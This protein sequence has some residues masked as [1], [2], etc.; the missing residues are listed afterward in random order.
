MSNTYYTIIDSS[1][2]SP[3]GSMVSSQNSQ[4]EKKQKI[5]N[6]SPESS[7]KVTEISIQD[8]KNYVN[9]DYSKKKQKHEIEYEYSD[10]SDNDFNPLFNEEKRM[11]KNNEKDQQ[12]R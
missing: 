6:S 11:R 7:N 9:S 2:S 5:T 3:E 10:E 4:V 1:E 8:P 12:N